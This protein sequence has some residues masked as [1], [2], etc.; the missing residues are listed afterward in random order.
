MAT[1]LYGYEL[2]L[3]DVWVDHS[4]YTYYMKDE[5]PGANDA[6]ETGAPVTLHGGAGAQNMFRTNVVV[7]RQA[8]EGRA[9][10]GF[11][12]EQRQKLTEK[13]KAAQ[14]TGEGQ[15]TVAGQPAYAWECKIALDKPLPT[16]RQWH[17]AV[18]RD[19]YAY[20]FCCTTEDHRYATL[21]PQFD[22]F[23]NS[24]H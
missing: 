4:V 2:T 19:D 3:P 22:A 9:L 13:M 21:K 20:S 17:V 24:W 10:D 23:V 5:A 11:V 7:V 18:I 1:S 15:L 8:A 16:L 12:K 14:L 6:A